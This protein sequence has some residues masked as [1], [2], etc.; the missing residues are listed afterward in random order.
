M[1]LIKRT[2]VIALLAAMFLSVL[3]L[4]TDRP[5]I[6]DGDGACE[7]TEICLADWNW[8]GWA[9]WSEDGDEWWYPGRTYDATGAS[10]D[11]NSQYVRNLGT[12]CHVT[13]ASGTNMWGNRKL[14]LMNSGWVQHNTTNVTAN[15]QSSHD[16][17]FSI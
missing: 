17:C 9:V 6:A 11:N 14:I 7:S 13:I 4:T 12:S 1:K 10:V 5:A 2:S 15:T 3:V 16:F 8:W